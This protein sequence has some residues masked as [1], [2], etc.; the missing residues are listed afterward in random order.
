MIGVTR[1]IG[2]LLGAAMVISSLA[3]PAYSQGLTKGGGYDTTPPFEKPQ[4]V[5]EKAY[6]SAIDRIPEPTQKY[7]PWGAARPAEPEKTKKKSN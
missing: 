3:V 6:K 4:K 1:A 2:T 7:D 5:D